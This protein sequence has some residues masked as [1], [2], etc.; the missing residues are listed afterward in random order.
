MEVKSTVHAFLVRMVL[1]P[2][3][4][5]K[6]VEVQYFHC[7]ALGNSVLSI[8]GFHFVLSVTVSDSSS[9]TLGNLQSV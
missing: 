4:S 2:P 5:A 1:K 7:L 6:V 8:G 9:L 3:E